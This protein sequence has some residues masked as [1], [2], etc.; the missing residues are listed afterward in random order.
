MYA[1]K[2]RNEEA[3]YTVLINQLKK[4]EKK[5]QDLNNMLNRGLKGKINLIKS[6]G[7]VKVIKRKLNKRLNNIEDIHRDNSNVSQVNY[8]STDRVAIYTCIIGRYDHLI[9]PTF[10]PDN[11][12]FY[13]ITDFPIPSSSKWNRIDLQKFNLDKTLSKVEVNRYFKM[14]PHIIFPTYKYSIYIDG[15]IRMST[16]PTEF[17]NR[18][19]KDGMGFF[20]H[21]HRNSIYREA[22]ACLILKKARQ[23][24]IEKWVNFL[25]KERMPENYGL[26]QCSVIARDHSSTIMKNVMREWWKLFLSVDAKRDQLLL[27]YVL[28][29]SN[30]KVEEVCTLGGN[31]WSYPGLETV[32]HK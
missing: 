2:D 9:E 22:E 29:K 26:I 21:A 19:S 14:M 27:P 1:R 23:A 7:I 20:A 18:I 30:I 15:N 8:F 13:A 28:F 10:C 5:N 4:D 11:C 31:V 17:V 32:G 16:D 12:D 6:E 3:L 25:K 24:D